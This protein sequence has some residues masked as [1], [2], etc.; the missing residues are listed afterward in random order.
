ML[1]WR[2]ERSDAEHALGA[3]RDAGVLARRRRPRPHGRPYAFERNTEI[4][5]EDEPAEYIYKV[6]S[7]AVRLPS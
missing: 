6:V 1:H 7:G 2:G 4:F 5:G 3:L